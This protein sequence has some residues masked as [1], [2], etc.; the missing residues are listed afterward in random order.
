MLTLHISTVTWIHQPRMIVVH[1]PTIL[2]YRYSIKTGIADVESSGLYSSLFW[3]S[4]AVFRII[5]AFCIKYPVNSKLRFIL[6]SISVL[7]VI[8]LLLQW[9]GLYQLL[10]WLSTIYFGAMLSCIY[11][12]CLAFPID[13]GFKNTTSNSANFVMAYCIGEGIMPAPLGYIMGVFGHRS[14]IVMVLVTC[15]LSWWALEKA[16]DSM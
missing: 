16:V 4:N 8:L 7:S 6:S 12:F 13:N 2:T 9:A 15:L 11:G 1:H 14:L 3:M 10:C 5:W